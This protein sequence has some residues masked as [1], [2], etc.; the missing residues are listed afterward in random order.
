MNRQNAER[1]KALMYDFT[2]KVNESLHEIKDSESQEEFVAYR[3]LVA[4]LMGAMLDV[5]RLVYAYHPDL[6]PPEPKD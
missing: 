2:A 1:M 4:R 5:L 3:R 6:E